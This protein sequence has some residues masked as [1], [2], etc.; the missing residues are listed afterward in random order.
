MFHYYGSKKKL[1]LAVLDHALDMFDRYLEKETAELP[2]DVLDRYLR[3]S[4]AKAKMFMEYP[5]LY[6][7]VSGV[8]RDTPDE[9][10]EEIAERQRR[11]QARYET[12]FLQGID[13][14]RFTPGFDQGRMLQLVHM[15]LDQLTHRYLEAF[16]PLPDRGLSRLPEVVQGFEE[17]LA[18]LKAGIYKE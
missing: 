6:K 5:L 2:P 18:I 8:F 13:D 1:F 12:Y 11:M 17:H 9:L 10:R 16:K 3:V 14:S 15:V 4:A 7:L